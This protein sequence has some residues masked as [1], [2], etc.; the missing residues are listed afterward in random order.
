MIIKDTKIIKQIFKMIKLK[1]NIMKRNFGFFKKNS[2]QGYFGGKDYHIDIK[3][4]KVYV[5]VSAR[6]EQK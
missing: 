2:G 3:M 4:V 6:N 1:K 5:T